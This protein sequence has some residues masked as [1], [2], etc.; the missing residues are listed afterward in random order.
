MAHRV[1]GPLVR[2]GALAMLVALLSVSGLEA[3]PVEVRFREGVP[4][5][6]LALR[7]ADGATVA[8]GQSRERGLRE[9]VDDV[10]HPRPG[11]LSGL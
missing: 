10:R 3:A 6:L 1:S 11:P 2:S 4:H 9:G 5:G 7:S 8:L